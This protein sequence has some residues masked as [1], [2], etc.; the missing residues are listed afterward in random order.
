M[1]GLVHSRCEYSRRARPRTDRPDL[2]PWHRGTLAHVWRKSFEGCSTMTALS[3]DEL[4]AFLALPLTARLG[5]VTLDG[6]PF[7]TPV[8]YLWDGATMYF[9]VRARAEYFANI[10]ANP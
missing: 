4:N 6:Y 2:V 10:R 1:A 7:V 9:Y 8:L 3:P 5:S